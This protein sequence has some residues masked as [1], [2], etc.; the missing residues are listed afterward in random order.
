MSPRGSLAEAS[1]DIPPDSGVRRKLLSDAQRE[2]VA[3]DE[4][5]EPW[6]LELRGHD[7][8]VVRFSRP[9]SPKIRYDGEAYIFALP[10]L[11]V[12]ERAS[13]WQEAARCAA[14]R[15]ASEVNR[16][17]RT[18]PDLLT[19]EE[20]AQRRALLAHVNLLG[21]EIG[22]DFPTE[23]RL[24]GYLRGPLFVPLQEDDFRPIPVPAA[25]QRSP[26]DDTLWLARV[27]TWR[28]GR[29]KG[30]V[31]ELISAEGKGA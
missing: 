7:P 22:L 6:W 24:L 4:W 1:W 28:D 26:G 21:G 12:C 23:R 3:S 11:S 20:R 25:L 2:D 5:E 27:A 18:F 9:V 17:T 10:A 15:I 29:P 19:K 13:S 30:E 8:I 14:D 16:L 31:L